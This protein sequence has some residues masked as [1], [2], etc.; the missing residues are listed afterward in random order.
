[1]IRRPA[2][3]PTPAALLFLTLP[4]ALL[5]GCASSLSGLS[6]SSN[7]AC[8]AP[9]GVTCQSV[10]A[11]YANSSVERVAA[12]RGQGSTNAAAAAPS[13]APSVP[14]ATSS[15]SQPLVASP[16]PV[17]SA[18]AFTPSATP[19]RSAPL[20]LRLW[21]KAWEDVDGDLFDQGH[22]YVQID[23]GRW[24]VEHAQRT[25]REAHSPVRAAAV[26][27]AGEPPPVMPARSSRSPTASPSRPTL[28]PLP[29]LP[30]RPVPEDASRDEERD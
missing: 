4:I 14:S 26:R 10:S 25:K 3:R 9:E 16:P 24:L 15:A 23:G 18:P 5:C 19:I 21:F 27:G 30:A 8:K 11:T 1:M 7:Y 17:P 22:I 29:V 2:H 12:T 20:I 6:G 28:P 13:A